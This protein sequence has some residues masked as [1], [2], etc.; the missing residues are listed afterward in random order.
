ME[1]YLAGVWL[2]GLIIFSLRRLKSR[3]II[4]SI[5]LEISVDDV[6][7]DLK[8]G[9]SN[10]VV[11]VKN[12]V[13]SIIFDKDIM[14]GYVNFIIKS[15]AIDVMIIIKNVVGFIYFAIK[16]MAIYLRIAT[17]GNVIAII[18]AS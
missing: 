15:D 16:S 8:I 10:R 3:S 9:V 7:S 13:I 12:V 17:S 11:I 14:V 1:S 18:C 2:A 5:S 6:K 4:I